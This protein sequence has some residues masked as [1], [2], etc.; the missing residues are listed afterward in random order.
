MTIII[1]MIIIVILMVINDKQQPLVNMIVILYAQNFFVTATVL[2][3]FGSTK[4]IHPS[5]YILSTSP[6]YTPQLIHSSLSIMQD[7][8]NR[9]S[10]FALPGVVKELTFTS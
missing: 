6:A 9:T 7:V 1:I 10:L 3:M 8:R 5:L 4:L 2:G